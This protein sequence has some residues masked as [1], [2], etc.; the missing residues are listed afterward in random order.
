[1]YRVVTYAEAAEQIGA[2]PAEALPLFAEAFGVL[3]LAPWNG[4][5]YNASKP[6]GEMRELVFGSLGTVTYLV[7]EPQREVHILLVQWVG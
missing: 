6:D 4:R 3:E 2:L 1:M 5:P 7:L